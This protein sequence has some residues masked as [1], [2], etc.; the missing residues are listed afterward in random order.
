MKVIFCFEMY[1]ADFFWLAKM[2]KKTLVSHTKKHTI[3]LFVNNFVYK[4][5]FTRELRKGREVQDFEIH[6]RKLYQ[7]FIQFVQH[8]K[9]FMIFL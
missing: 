8:F 2:M 9:L 4:I 6:F 5:L 1:L 3:F 7:Y